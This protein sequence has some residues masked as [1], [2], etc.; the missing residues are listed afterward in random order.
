M[1]QESTKIS[2]STIERATWRAIKLRAAIITEAHALQTDPEREKR[3]DKHLCPSC[4]YT[5]GSRIAGAAITFRP[6]GVCAI[7]QYYPS[8]S[9]DVLC[10]ACAKKEHLCCHCG[11]DVESQPRTATLTKHTHGKRGS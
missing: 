10:T 6:C 3:R 9:T 8:T 7:E 11:G 5:R 4:Y 1:R 2:D